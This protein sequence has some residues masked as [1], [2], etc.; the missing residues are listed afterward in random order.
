MD[1]CNLFKHSNLLFILFY[2]KLHFWLSSLAH[3]DFISST[4][5]LWTCVHTHTKIVSSRWCIEHLITKIGRNG[6][7]P[8]RINHIPMRI[9]NSHRDKANSP[10]LGQREL[11]EFLL[12]FPFSVEYCKGILCH[13]YF[14]LLHQT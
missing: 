2:P 14:L 7:E 1:M 4:C 12:C 5:L 3:L 11:P 10:V 9:S 13:L 6:L 8:T